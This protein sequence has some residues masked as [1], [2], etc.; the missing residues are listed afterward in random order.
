MTMFSSFSGPWTDESYSAPWG[1]SKQSEAIIFIFFLEKRGL[2]LD[3]P[4][5]STPN[6]SLALAYDVRIGWNLGAELCESSR[7]AQGHTHI[8]LLAVEA[9]VGRLM[10]P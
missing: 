2:E 3:G 5:F 10:T 8:R 7:S 4:T 1:F 6:V 9:F